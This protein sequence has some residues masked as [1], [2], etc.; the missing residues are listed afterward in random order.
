[1][2]VNFTSKNDAKYISMSHGVFLRN[3]HGQEVLLRPEGITWRTIGGSIDLYF[4]DGPTQKEVIRAYHESATG[5]P[6]LQ[7]YWT[8]GFHQCRW[9]YKNWTMLADVVEGYK[10]AGIPLETIW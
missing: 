3:I 6:A 9:G 4:Y 1:V 7:Q 2:G 10:N 5:L 8:F